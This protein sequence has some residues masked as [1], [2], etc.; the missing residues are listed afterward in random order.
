MRT[1]VLGML[2]IICHREAY[3]YRAVNCFCNPFAES[4]KRTRSSAN[5]KYTIN[6]VSTVIPSPW[7]ND[8]DISCRNYVNNL[9][10]SIPPCR[11]P[12]SL[13]NISLM[14]ESHFT[15]HS[16]LENILFIT[17]K[18]LPSIPLLSNLSFWPQRLYL[19]Y[20]TLISPYA[21]MAI[22][23]IYQPLVSVTTWFYNHSYNHGAILVF[24]ST[25]YLSFFQYLIWF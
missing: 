5:N 17:F 1:F 7:S 24:T 16:A 13:F 2:T 6:K 15:R 10:L 4:E 9:G 25:H 14:H 19:W 8:L 18:K 21:R 12:N 11:T 3:L 23:Q 20:H 22:D